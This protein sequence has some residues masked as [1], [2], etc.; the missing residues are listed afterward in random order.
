MPN[1]R[2]AKLPA[3]K[4]ILALGKS[5]SGK[6]TQMWTLPGKKFLYQFDPNTM[7]TLLGIAR[8]QKIE[9]PDIE[10]EEF[11]M[12]FLEQDQSLKAFNKGA[13]DDKLFK[14]KREPTAYND[15][16]VDLNERV[17]DDYFAK[18]DISW[19]CFDGLTFLNKAIMS[20]QLFIN[21]R[22]GGLEDKPDYRIVGAKV[23]E[24]FTA[25]ASLPINIFMTG[26]INTFQDEKTQRIETLIA[27]HGSSRTQLPMIFSD[28]WL[29]KHEEYKGASRYTI[30]T[31][32]EERGLQDIRS[33]I[34]GLSEVEDVTIEDFSKAEE[35]GIGAILADSNH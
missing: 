20:R 21:D 32:P 31:R 5:G 9:P 28:I 3:Y 12:D 18:Q 16:A 19:L 27:A 22:V 24:I 2:E 30:R 10:Y 8:Q 23:V 6:T 11:Q 29:F 17:E 25:L 34:Q 26:H 1:I 15:F 35:F 7:A 4:R 14:A 33:S 13:K